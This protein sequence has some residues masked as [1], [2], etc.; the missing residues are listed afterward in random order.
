MHAG[1]VWLSAECPFQMH[2]QSPLTTDYEIL[3]IKSA[4]MHQLFN[5]PSIALKMFGGYFK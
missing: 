3:Y 5:V 1:S 2:G 4:E